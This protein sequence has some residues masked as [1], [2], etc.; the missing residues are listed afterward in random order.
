[1]VHDDDGKEREFSHDE[2]MRH[3][4]D[5]F[6][7]IPRTLL[8]GKWSPH[9]ENRMRRIVHNRLLEE[10]YLLESDGGAFQGF[11][12]KGKI[13][14]SVKRARK[15]TFFFIRL[16]N[17]LSTIFH[18]PSNKA[19]FCH[20]LSLLKH[21]VSSGLFCRL[22]NKSPTKMAVAASNV[23]ARASPKAF[24]QDHRFLDLGVCSRYSHPLL[25]TLSP[26]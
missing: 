17:D 3:L 16:T 1:M 19:S 18:F 8:I 20:Y 7:I 23:L 4:F 15:G 26:F 24:T 6:I 25:Y 10:T 13:L 9:A 2:S 12:R 22:Y 14:P 11:A 5:E 21:S